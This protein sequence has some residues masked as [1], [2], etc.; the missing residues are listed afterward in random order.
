MKRQVQ[1]QFRVERMRSDH[2]RTRLDSGNGDL[3]R[4]LRENASQAMRGD[5][6]RVWV[7][8][9]AEG[10]AVVGYYTLGAFT[11][12]ADAMPVNLGKRLPKRIPIPA[13]LMGKL[14]VDK[15]FAGQ[16]IGTFLL[17]DGLRRAWRQSTEV[18]SVGVVVDA[19]DAGIA[20][21]YETR[22]FAPFPQHPL[23]LILPMQDIE[24]LFGGE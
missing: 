4:W 6:A 16:G 14:A 24:R 21:W 19:V 18:A 5:T 2:D 7:L 11:L 1:T 17:A 23:R 12:V 22:G 15:T 9:P 3:D 10:G 20:G 13:T 8:V